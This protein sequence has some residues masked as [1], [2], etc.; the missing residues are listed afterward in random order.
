MAVKVRRERPDQ[1]RHHRVT[2]PLFVE[3]GGHRLRAADWSL[4]GLRVEAYPDAVPPTG[5]T[6]TLDLTLPFQGFDVSF[7]V[8]AEVLRTNPSVGMFAV[9][10]TKLGERE[11]ELM[12]HFVE[13]L[14]RGLM[15]DVADTIQRIDVPVTPASLQPDVK[16][17][18]APAPARPEAAPP[19]TLRSRLPLSR[20]PAKTLAMSAFYLVMGFF[21]FGYAGLLGYSNF[22]RLEVQTAVITAPLETVEAQVD[23]RIDMTGLRPGDEVRSGQV[24]LQLFD[25]QLEREIELADIA[26][27][28]R[29][30]KLAFLKRRHADELDRIRGFATV[31]MKNVK[32]TKLN[33]ESLMA[34]LETARRH[35][36]R[37]ETLSRKGFTTAAKLDEAESRVVKL[38][39]QLARAEIELSSRV[40]LADSNLGRRL[41]TGDDLIGKVDEL[42]A[43]V[44][45]AEHE[46]ALA[47]QRH[48]ASM[49][50]RASR[51]VRAPFDGTI[52]S[53]PRHAD[54]SVRRGDVVAVI[55]QRRNREVTAFLNQDEVLKIGMGDEALLYLPALG[56]SLKGRVAS[57]DRTSGFIREQ[58]QRA[59]PGYSWRGPTDRSARVTI[60]FDD[61]RQVADYERYRSGLPV[62]VVF[63]QRSTNSLISSISP[64]LSLL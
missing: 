8:E 6:V 57:I 21:V 38:E 56:E 44:R 27:K 24:I 19:A 51:S 25:S 13:E 20:I 1:R 60:R 15:S 4:G 48:I 46:V 9:Q 53:L 5:A 47:Q 28:E 33:V 62:V 52:L 42:D 35:L 16:S 10:F 29:K 12:Q 50:M 14:V 61:P 7:T 17:A 59:N 31:E 45:L 37:V 54:A 64:K 18:P 58:E 26:V 32:Q 49:S 40:E 41:Y 22:F 36:G 43:Q 63:E 34:E 11:R 30:A 39:K 23:G 3:V 55:E 2:A